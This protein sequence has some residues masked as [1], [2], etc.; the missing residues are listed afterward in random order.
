MVHSRSLSVGATAADCVFLRVENTTRALQ[1]LS[2]LVREKWSGIVVAV[3]GSMGKTTTRSFVSTLLRQHYRVRESP[4][5]LNNNFGVPLSLLGVEERDEIAVVELAMNHPGEIRALSLICRPDIAVITNVAPVHLE[6]FDSIDQIAEA[7]AE[8][9]EGLRERGRLLFNAEDRRLCA[10]AGNFTGSTMSFGASDRCQV[11]VTGEHAADLHR[12]EV[13]IRTPTGR[14]SARL[15]FSGRHYLCNLAAAI[16]IAVA[17]GLTDEA[18]QNGIRRLSPVSQRGRIN[19]LSPGTGIE[20]TLV[21]ESYNSNP[22]AL[23]SVLEDFSR[24][25]WSGRKLAVL[26]DM[27]ELGSQAKTYHREVGRRL[28]GLG[29]DIVI[30]VGDLTRETRRGAREAG[31]PAHRLVHAADSSQA[32]ELVLGLLRSGD[33]LLVKASRGIGLDRMIRQLEAGFEVGEA[34]P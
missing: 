17:L 3:T 21:D 23:N 4:G 26:G 34:S 32:A 19:L 18:I 14:Y 8:I 11:S 28:A 15:P 6:F 12:M 2:S 25:L 24:W 10:I 31:V 29:L 13:T 27:L 30:T 20:F 33:L 22:E 16:A 5:N 1:I 7:K 9:L